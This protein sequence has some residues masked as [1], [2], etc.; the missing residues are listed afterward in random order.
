MAGGS[1]LV[2]I[3]VG[4]G[5]RLVADSGLDVF[6]GRTLFGAIIHVEFVVTP[7]TAETER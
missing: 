3:T 2:S 6:N 5:H 1:V 4:A 7:D